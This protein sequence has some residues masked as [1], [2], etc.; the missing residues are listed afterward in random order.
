MGNFIGMLLKAYAALAGYAV[1]LVAIVIAVLFG[2]GAL[3]ADRAREA[4]AVLR[5]KPEPA[6]AKATP[7]EKPAEPLTPERVR[8]MELRA[9]ELRRLEDRVSGQ[10]LQ[11]R[12]E[13]ETLSRKAQEAAAAE[14]SLRKAR[15]DA[16]A[17]QSDAEIAANLPILSKLDGPGILALMKSWEDPRIVK[18]LR[19]L[20]P[21]KAAEVLETLRTDP[22]FEEEFRKIP[23]ESP[24]G[25]KS[26]AERL[27]EAFSKAP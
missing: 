26:R 14:A 19:A 8:M 11:L 27:N 17:A 6:A 13:Q 1:A 22:Q 21:G 20:K 5:K 23:P 16:A 25:T 7:A 12:A 18:Y 10:I 24:P 3:S 2:S 15:E 9:E 4:L